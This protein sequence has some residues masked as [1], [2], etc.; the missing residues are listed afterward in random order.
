MRLIEFADTK[1]YILSADDA[2][3]FLKQL[4][5]IWLHD[6]LHQRLE[7]VTPRS[8]CRPSPQWHPLLHSRRR[9]VVPAHA[10]ECHPIVA[11]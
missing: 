1:P 9:T 11:R 3:D 8:P 4:E 6:V 2:A 10:V 5:R 7:T